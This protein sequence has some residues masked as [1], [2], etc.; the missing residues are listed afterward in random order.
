[1]GCVGVGLGGLRVGGWGVG[2]WGVEGY[3]PT[4]KPNQSN[5]IHN[6]NQ[7]RTAPA[8]PLMEYLSQGSLHRLY[9]TVTWGWLGG[10]VVSEGCRLGGLLLWGVGFG[11]LVVFGLF[12]G[13]VGGF[14]LRV[15]ECVTLPTRKANP[16]K[17]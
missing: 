11:W 9:R 2:G 4:P 16:R 7:N 10:L 17:I 3:N 13:G 6:Q 12:R 5:P 15:C 1:V 14:A 8:T